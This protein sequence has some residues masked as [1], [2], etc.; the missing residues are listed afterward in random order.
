MT[1]TTD[2]P[3]AE[4][5]QIELDEARREIRSLRADL[6]KLSRQRDADAALRL[7]AERQVERHR[8]QLRAIRNSLSWRLTRPIR[9]VK[10]RIKNNG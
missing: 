4:A 6:A 10:R 5:L 7:V 2:F 3:R 1:S 8:H 9:I